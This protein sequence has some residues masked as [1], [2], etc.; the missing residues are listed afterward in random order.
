MKIIVGLVLALLLSGCQL[1][2]YGHLVG[3]HRALMSARQPVEQ[4]LQRDDLDP[5]LRHKLELSVQLREFAEQQLGLPVDQAY[6]EYAELES[7]WVTWNLFAAPPL[8]LQPK[9]WCY[10]VVGCASYHGYFDQQRAERDAE[11]LRQQGLEVYAGGAIAYS[12][13]GWFDDPLTTPMLAGSDLWF[14]ELL[15]HE[16][17]HRRFYLKGDTRFNE[18]LATAVGRAGMQ[19]WLSSRGAG[20]AEAH[21][22]LEARERARQQVL[23]LVDD[24][25]QALAELYATTLPE[26]DKLAQRDQLRQTLRERFALAA[27]DDPALSRYQQW[28][29]GPLNNAQLATLA[30]YESLVPGF[31]AVLA[32]CE[33]QW[34]CFW[35][36]VEQIAALPAE[37][38]TQTLEYPDA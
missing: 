19:Q 13:L 33:Q 34:P 9:Q 28:F 3:G 7:D 23:A 35:Q 18:S 25:R 12:T 4:V 32:Q 5:A 6:S 11:K 20:L 10:P 24:T 1:G 38:R 15:F 17:A 27:Q 2:Y 14:A 36:R 30:D 8:S 22:Q 37:Q 26:A 16:L 29:D 31:D 21:A